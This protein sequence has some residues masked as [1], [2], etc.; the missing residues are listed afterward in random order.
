MKKTTLFKT[1]LLLCALVVG[2][3]S[4]WAETV[5]KTMNTIV[6]ENSYTVS[7]G[8][9]ATCY[10]SFSLD[11]N[12]TVST[13]GTPNCGSFWGTTTYDWRLYQNQSGNIIITAASGYTLSSV[14]ITYDAGKNGILK[15]GSATVSSGAAQ[16]ISGSSKTYTV[17]NTGSA[18]NG[19]VRVTQISVTYAAESSDPVINASNI[20]IAVGATSGEIAYTITNPVADTDLTA[21]ITAGGT[22]LSDATVDEDKVTF[23]ST[24]NTGAKR[25]GTIHLVYGDNLATK[26]ITVTQAGI[27]SITYDTK[28]TNGTLVVKNGDAVVTSGTKLP[29]GTVLT[30]VPTPA[31]NYALTNWQYKKGEG[32]WVSKSANFE[33]TIDDN[34]VAFRANFE[35]TYPV[36]F[37][38]NGQITST[39]RFKKDEKITFPSATSYDGFD[40]V[41]W[42]EA[43]ID[44]SVAVEPTLVDT[45]DETMGTEEKT[46]YAVYGRKW[47]KDVSV[48]FDPSDYPSH[49]SDAER[50]YTKEGVTLYMN[51]GRVYGG[52]PR[53][54]SVKAGTSNYF[55]ISLDGTL[56]SVVT[57]I[58]KSANSGYIIGSV[59]DGAVLGDYDDAS[60]TQT[61]TFSKDKVQVQC[62]ATS[63][64]IRASL[65]V[66]NAV[67][68]NC[69]VDYQTTLTQPVT[70]GAN[71]YTTFASTSAL[72]L[73]DENRPEGLKAYKATL[74]G[75]TLSFAALDQ[76]VP[77]GTGLLLLGETKGGTYYIPVA[78]S[79][80]AITTALVGVITTPTAKQ[81]VVD[82]TY[83]FVM[84]KATSA[85]DALAFAP[86]STSAAVTIPAG[87]AYVEVSNSAFE[88]PA[89]EL[90]IIFDEGETTGLADVRG[91]K[92]DVRGDYYNL[93][94]QRVA[95]PTKGLY[96]VNGR[97]VVIR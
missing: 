78:A 26:D 31:E 85:L 95:Q 39:S 47:V 57:T 94:G 59:S 8:N 28:Q 13:T 64:Q 71:G 73:T 34:D 65:I 10:T 58:D 63:K 40:F 22:W 62:F 4:V 45:D 60:E 93:N 12:I 14:T 7:S 66:V 46:Y 19:Q 20:D 36:N 61:V 86:L 51:S 92:A 35:V 29:V 53:T 2:S 74:T 79:G 81:S 48:T 67:M 6:S 96:I 76:T 69:I 90:S 83:Y 42:A 41:G 17:G 11:S 24:A 30:I 70:V 87:K 37:S 3:G 80:D 21:S 50:T 56:T 44:G 54:F 16:S 32:N 23:A 72:D 68:N 49:S 38:V 84:K 82:D 18:T 1:V 33:Y 89:R 15:D 25:T 88:T 5:T 97:K 91:K 75:S 55:K 9:T 27:Y 43:T 77:A 52:D